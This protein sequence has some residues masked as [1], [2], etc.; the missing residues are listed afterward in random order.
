MAT[1][2]E[3]K[4]KEFGPR[5]K[6]DLDLLDEHVAGIFGNFW[7]ETGGFTLLQEAN[8]LIKG[9]KGGWGWA[10]WTGPRRRAFEAWA[11][12]K[13]LDRAADETNYQYV[14]FELKG[15]EKNALRLLRLTTTPED[16]AETF[17]NKFE[18]PGIPHLAKRKKYA[19]VAYDFLKNMT[20][21]EK[22][23]LKSSFFNILITFILKLFGKK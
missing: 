8:P 14:I 2:Y 9:S 7:A 4:V 19:R 11:D 5:F 6:K 16:A 18:R 3:L 23:E 22:I 12:N 21:E 1:K 20:P 13:G 10:Q 15:P 17:C